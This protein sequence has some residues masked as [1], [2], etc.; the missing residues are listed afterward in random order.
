M[1]E[2]SLLLLPLWNLKNHLLAHQWQWVFHL[3]VRVIDFQF[4]VLF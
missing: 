1:F 3:R 4:N 2:T